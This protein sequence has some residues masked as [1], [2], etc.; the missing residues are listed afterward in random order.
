MHNQKDVGWNAPEHVPWKNVKSRVRPLMDSERANVKRW[1]RM[2]NRMRRTT[3]RSL[4][5]RIEIEFGYPSVRYCVAK[6]SQS[7]ACSRGIA[8]KP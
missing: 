3:A 7:A 1:R 8:F 2:I 5:L 6:I 4:Q